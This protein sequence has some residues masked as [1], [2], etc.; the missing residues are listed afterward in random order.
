MYE[1]SIHI[2]EKLPLCGTGVVMGVILIL[3]H[4]Y[5]LLRP[6]AALRVLGNAHVAYRAGA[7]LLGIDFLWI[8]ALL[9]KADWNPLCMPLYEFDRTRGILLI[10]CPI[11]WFVLSSMAKEH[12][13]ARALGLFLLL[14]AL[15]PL[16]AAFLKDPVTRLLIPIWWYPVLTVAMSGWPSPT[17]SGTGPPGSA[18]TRARSRASPSSAPC[19]ALPC[20]PAPSSS[21]KNPSPSTPCTSTPQTISSP[22]TT[23]AT[24][25]KR[26]P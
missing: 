17:F 6:E 21:G 18:T 16:S 13:F 20:S 25:L 23:D 3:L 11:I 1:Q 24:S 15:L 5:A 7:T 26:V 2:Y 4:L 22:K 9:F 10:L 12:L 19:T 8:A 14:A